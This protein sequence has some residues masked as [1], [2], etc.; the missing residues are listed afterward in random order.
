MERVAKDSAAE[1]AGLKVGDIL[2]RWS[3][4]ESKGAFESP[5]DLSEMNIEERPRGNVTI[6]GLRG[7]EEQTWVLGPSCPCLGDTT[8]RPN[9]SPNVMSTYRRTGQLLRAG[10]VKEAK[11]R[12]VGIALR[13]GGRGWLY[14]WLLIHQTDLLVEAHRWTKADQL[15]EEAS[16]KAPQAGPGVA[17]VIH[18]WW[19]WRF[20]SQGRFGEARAQYQQALATDLQWKAESLTVA[21]D[22]VGL[23]MQSRE[24]AEVKNYLR[25]AIAIREKLAPA[26]LELADSLN[27]AGYFASQE[28]G[29]GE[30]E[31]YL[32]RALR[33]Q[34]NLP[35]PNPVLG[36]TL[37]SLGA[38]SAIRGD[39]PTAE[40][41][42]RQ[43]L[44]LEDGGHHSR[45]TALAF[46]GISDV[47][48]LRGE[49]PRAEYYER[50]ALSIHKRLAPAGLDLAVSL[51]NLSG[52]SKDAGDLVKAEAYERRSLRIYRRLAPDDVDLAA[53]L[54]RMGNILFA[55]GRL[56]KAEDYYHQALSISEKLAPSG[57]YAATILQSLGDLYQKSGD[58]SKAEESY[59]KALDIW[60]RIAPRSRH[61]ADV[62]VG[63]ARLMNH[64][65]LRAEAAEFYDRALSVLEDQTARLGGGAEARS[66]FRARHLDPYR[67]YVDLLVQERQPEKALQVLERSRARSLV[68]MLS[69]AHIDVHR[70]V[71]S[72]LLR[73]EQTLQQKFA[74][75]SNQRLRL[76][77]GEHAEEQ[78]KTLDKEI[79]DLLAQQQDLE[80]QIRSSSPEY[81]AHDAATAAERQ[82]SSAAI[83]RPGHGLARVLPGRR[84]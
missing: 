69:T 45:N 21:V 78:L 20:S 31:S 59:R 41:Y 32:Q 24:P 11:K 71:D 63:L 81:A 40:R 34:E 8:A 53:G 12:W 6:D 2:L 3:R 35:S 84:A 47:A 9:F 62:L 38:A 51:H 39:L 36:Y 73:Q 72:G 4:G 74:G 75:K 76:L 25:Q 42:Y 15:L 29:L 43:A 7:A 14:P 33:A 19:A 60:Q 80:G 77:S 49:L 54:N 79:A 82:G 58:L 65:E 17:A 61:P 44:S 55:R 37:T 57:F 1:R 5:F 18:R 23:A 10:K 83:A 22:L 28:S 26:S 68:E 30:A 52:I 27:R 66:G 70:G 46:S 48:W 64:Q 50:E 16:R 13:N 56:R 67:E